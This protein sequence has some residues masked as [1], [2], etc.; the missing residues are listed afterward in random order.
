MDMDLCGHEDSSPHLSLPV[1]LRIIVGIFLLYRT[2]GWSI[3]VGLAIMVISML[4]NFRLTTEKYKVSKAQMENRDARAQLM[5]AC[6]SSG[7]RPV[8]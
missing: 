5:V 8:I 3:F 1:P 7:P 2:L 6:L 4:M